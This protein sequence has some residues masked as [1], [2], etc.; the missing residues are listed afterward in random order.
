MKRHDAVVLAVVVL[1]TG[2]CAG[3]CASTK[4]VSTWK[5]PSF[6]GPI[7]F[8][9]IVVF[10]FDV[11]PYA[12]NVAEDVVVERIGADRAVASHDFLTDEDRTSTDRVKEKLKQGGVDGAITLALAGSR[13]AMSR[14]AGTPEPFYGYYDRSNAFVMNEYGFDTSTKYYVETRIYDVQRDRVIW[15]AISETV[16]P[17]QV[18]QATQDIAKAVG[19]ELR[20]QK[21]IR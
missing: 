7:E 9:K 18:H 20:K 13:T 19:A 2:L 4:I 1:V 11:D 17:K 6:T 16:D 15:R 12:R 8:K 3:G 14:D 10:G 5:D 21:L